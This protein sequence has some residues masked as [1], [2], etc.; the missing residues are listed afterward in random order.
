[1]RFLGFV[2]V[3]AILS[4]GAFATPVSA[5][6]FF[7]G[8]TIQAQ[9]GYPLGPAG[10]PGNTFE[11]AAVQSVVG[12]GVEFTNGQFTPFFGPSFDFGANTIAISQTATGHSSAVFNGWSFF[13]VFGTI[14][15]ITGVTVVSDSS[16]FFSSNPS[17]ISFDPN[18]IFINFQG[19]SFPTE[20]NIQ[21]AV[22]FDAAPVPGPIVGAGLPGLI[23]AAGGLLAWRR[24]KQNQFAA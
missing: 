23:M 19:L 17:R 9:A 5:N 24:R 16:G 22:T 15:S 10:T 20:S 12:A 8:S 11:S 7:T 1:M 18:H 13:D 3:S 21:L 6:S 14:D 4:V 2:A